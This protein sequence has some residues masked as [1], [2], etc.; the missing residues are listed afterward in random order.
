LSTLLLRL[1]GPLQSW[2]IN[3]KYEIRRTEALPSKS[4]VIG[5][6][7]AALGRTRD[8]EMSDLNGLR[9]G[10]RGDLPGEIRYDYQTAKSE[11]SYIINRYYVED[12]IFLVGLECEDDCFL[13]KLEY[14]LKHPRFHLF[15]G[16]KSCPPTLPFILGIRSAPLEQALRE[17]PWLVPDW[18]KKKASSLLR[19]LIDCPNGEKANAVQRD[20][21]ISFSSYRREYRNRGVNMFYIDKASERSDEHDPMAELE[22][23]NVLDKN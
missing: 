11:K 1:A 9:F 19:I 17:E 7:A 12:G 20:V 14:A 22:E 8:E 10:V 16:R 3:S 18:R 6:L 21:P 15:L 5:L 2:G 13:E 23:D 4:A